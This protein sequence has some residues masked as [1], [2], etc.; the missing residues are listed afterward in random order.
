MD[1]YVYLL[2]AYDRCE[3]MYKIG[4][5]GNPKKRLKQFPSMPFRTKIIHTI[6]CTNSYV[7]ESILHRNFSKKRIRG[8]WFQLTSE[9]VKLILGYKVESD[10]LPNDDNHPVRGCST[11]KLVARNVVEL[12]SMLKK[13]GA[14]TSRDISEM[15]KISRKLQDKIF[16]WCDPVSFS[17]MTK[18]ANFL[19]DDVEVFDIAKTEEGKE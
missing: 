18:I 7:V 14:H 1:S 16:I 17:T 3:G 11:A 10:V 4:K 12:K 19:G 9:D 5:A 6:R 2:K 13:C 8:E 15:V